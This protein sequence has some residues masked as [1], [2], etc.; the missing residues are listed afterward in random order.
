MQNGNAA[1]Q[2]QVL[3]A[4]KNVHV[5]GTEVV[6]GV[7]TTN[8]RGTVTASTA[9]ATLRPSLRKELAPLL[10]LVT[11]GI[12]FD[13]WIDVQ[14]VTRRLVE[15]E[16]IAGEQATVTLN[17]TAVNQPVQVTLPPASQVGILPK[18]QLGGL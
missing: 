14:H 17:V 8:Y 11:G 3:T 1:Q 12:H 5:V 16:P 13:V 7:E 18:S 6:N 9:L 4:S 10:R 2:T 15:V